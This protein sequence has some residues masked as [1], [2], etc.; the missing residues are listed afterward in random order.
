MNDEKILKIC[1]ITTIVG[2]L[3]IIILSGYVNPEKISINQITKSKIDNQIELDAQ[4][5]SIQQTKSK[6]TIIKLKDE[7]GEINMVIFPTTNMNTK[8]Q[9]KEK[10]NVICKVTQYNGQMELILEEPRNIKIIN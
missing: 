8:L 4:I 9:N 6:T 5:I 3:G 7:T 10:I 2:L 1:I